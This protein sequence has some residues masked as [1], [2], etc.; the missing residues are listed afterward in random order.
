M[1]D[2]STSYAYSYELRELQSTLGALGRHPGS[3]SDVLQAAMADAENE[4]RDEAIYPPEVNEALLT[5][6]EYLRNGYYGSAG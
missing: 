1:T 4:A 5:I 6:V 2:R 3:E